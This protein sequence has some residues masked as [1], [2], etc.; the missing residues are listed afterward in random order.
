MEGLHTQL[1]E[2]E[3]GT[4]TVARCRSLWW[5]LYIIDR[6]FS[7][8]LGVPMTTPDSEITTNFNET[9][10]LAERGSTLRLQVSLSQLLSQII[11]STPYL[12]PPPSHCLFISQLS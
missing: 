10:N 12:S 1:P 4:D 9:K 5:M 8:S 7:S 6:H 3:L 2:E 11:T